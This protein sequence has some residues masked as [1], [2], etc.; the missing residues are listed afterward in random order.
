MNSLI[1]KIA[2]KEEEILTGLNEESIA[3]YSFLKNEYRKG[4]ILNNHVFQF[5]FRSYYRL[6]NAGLSP[7]QKK[8]YFEM[9][10]EKIEDLSFILSE[11]YELPTLK[12]RKSIQFSFATK[13]LNMLDDNKPI[14]DS[15]I[16]NLTKLKVKGSTK[17]EK[18]VSCVKIYE[19]LTNLYLQLKLENEMRTLIAKFRNRFIRYNEN[20]SDTRALDFIIWSLGKAEA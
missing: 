11:L 12:N 13:L 2:A 14:F 1:D 6:D 3:V 5:A 17:S 10:S 19:S 20:I 9:L 8:R 4:D 16:S 15:Y 7:I 18:I